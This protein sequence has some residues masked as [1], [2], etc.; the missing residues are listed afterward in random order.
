MS[1][2]L[3]RL[4]HEVRTGSTIPKPQAQGEFKVKGWGTRRGEPA[5]IYTIPNHSTP[6][7]PYE[8]G[9]TEREWDRAF[10]QLKTA[11]EF[12]SAVVQ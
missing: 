9:V 5:L 11:G 7:R 8:K 2:L 3:K 1:E 6:T 12:E 10:Q 4:R